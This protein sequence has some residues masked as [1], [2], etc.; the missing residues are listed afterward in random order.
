FRLA[1]PELF[2][3]KYES[4]S[5]EDGLKQRIDLHKN[6]RS[7]RVVLDSINFIF[8]QIMGKDLG[9]IVYDQ[10]AA[11]Y[12][13]AD[14]DENAEGIS[15]TSELL[16]VNMDD[17]LEGTDEFEEDDSIEEMTQKEL[18]ARAIGKRIKELIHPE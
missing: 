1:R 12:V 3:E 2:M 17:N 11:L 8:E 6:F 7:R 15:N 4:Y 5:L 9:G 14:Y 18:E 10:D 16:L 13:G